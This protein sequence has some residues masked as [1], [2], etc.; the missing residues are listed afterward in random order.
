MPEPFGPDYHEDRATTP[1]TTR[2]ARAL[3]QLPTAA[4]HARNVD[5]Q[6]RRLLVTKCNAKVQKW[7]SIASY[8]RSVGDA[9]RCA[10]AERIMG[11][12]DRVAARLRG[13]DNAE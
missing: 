6:R 5:K 13:E 4:R 11:S 12:F 9:D 10:T 3:A 2:L 7:H 1:G 8:W